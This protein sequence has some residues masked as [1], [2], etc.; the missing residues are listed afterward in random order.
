MIFDCLL[1]LEH[2]ESVNKLSIERVNKFST[3]AIEHLPIRTYVTVP[4]PSGGSVVTRQAGHRL[5]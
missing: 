3:S 5:I 1:V 4:F 2:V